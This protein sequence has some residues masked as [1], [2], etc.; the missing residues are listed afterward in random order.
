[1]EPMRP[2]RPQ[3]GAVHEAAPDRILKRV[4]LTAIF[5]SRKMGFGSLTSASPEAKP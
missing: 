4:I 1:M 5:D 3:S 2:I